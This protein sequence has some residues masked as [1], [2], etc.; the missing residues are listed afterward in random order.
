VLLVELVLVVLLVPLVPAVY[1]QQHL[2]ILPQL[3][4][5]VIRGLIRIQAEFLF[6]MMDTGLKLVQLHKVQLVHK[7]LS[8]QLDRKV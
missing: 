4:Q 5:P 8:D 7:V 1:G 6:I 3:Q 2:L